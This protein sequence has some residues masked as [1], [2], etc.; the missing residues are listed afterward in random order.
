MIWNTGVTFGLFISATILGTLAQNKLSGD[1]GSSTQQG[2]SAFPVTTITPGAV[3]YSFQ[4]VVTAAL[5]TNK[6]TTYPI[7]VGQSGTLVSISIATVTLRPAPNTSILPTWSIPGYPQ[8]TSTRSSHS[9]RAVVVGG[10]LGILVLVIAIVAAVYCLCK[11]KRAPQNDWASRFGGQWHD[12]KG[13]ESG[14]S[15]LSLSNMS[16]SSIEDVTIPNA[17]LSREVNSPCSNGRTRSLSEMVT[18]IF[19]RNK[20]RRQPSDGGNVGPRSPTGFIGYG[21]SYDRDY[22]IEMDLNPGSQERAHVAQNQ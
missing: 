19:I 20:Y 2:L 21:S 3:V 11:R 10:I 8:P 1:A 5:P 18:P 9:H 22:P 15:G 14:A 7:T 17:S 16:E 4:P 12:L 13:K 6:V